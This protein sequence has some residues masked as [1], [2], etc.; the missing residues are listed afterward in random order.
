LGIARGAL[1]SNASEAG[2]AA[3]AAVLVTEPC[4]AHGSDPGVGLTGRG[5]LAVHRDVS[6]CN[7]VEGAFPDKGRVAAND[8][9]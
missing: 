2:A 1:Q 5:P 8:A 9:Q 3:I 6:G 7:L 4:H